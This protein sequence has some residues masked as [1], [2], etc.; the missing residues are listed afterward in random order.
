[1]YRLVSG[2]Q[3]HHQ[4]ILLLGNHHKEDLHKLRYNDI[5]IY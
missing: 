1:M 5:F 4:P 2:I 3:M